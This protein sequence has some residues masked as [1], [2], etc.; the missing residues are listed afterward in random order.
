MPTSV[1]SE[2]FS[3]TIDS[4]PSRNQVTPLW[5]L[6]LRDMFFWFTPSRTPYN[7]HLSGRPNIRTKKVTR[8]VGLKQQVN[9]FPR[10]ID[11]EVENA[12]TVDITTTPELCFQDFR[13]YGVEEV[14]STWREHRGC[15]DLKKAIHW[16]LVEG[17]ANDADTVEGAWDV[18]DETVK[19]LIGNQNGKGI[20]KLDAN[21]KM[22]EPKPEHRKGLALN[23]KEAPL[24]TDIKDADNVVLLKTKNLP[25]VG[26]RSS[27]SRCKRVLE[28]IVKAGNLLIVPRFYV[29]SKI[30]DSEGLSWFSIITTPNPMFT[31]LAGSIGAWKALSPEVLQA[32]FNVPADTE[33]VFRSKRTNDA[34][35]FPPPK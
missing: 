4:L 1:D 30:A 9:E 22:P 32:A 18:D 15:R 7:F 3:R 12:A 6:L 26:Q 5:D 29:V 25:L 23:C 10:L 16:L 21:V 2:S 8:I 17:M 28:T 33:K 14:I 34:I 13:M 24:D 35:F 27:P 19:A 11:R 31:H 20:I